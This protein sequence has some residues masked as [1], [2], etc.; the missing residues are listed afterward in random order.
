[1]LGEHSAQLS[2]EVDQ[3]EKTRSMLFLRVRVRHDAAKCNVTHK[4][5]G[6]AGI[7][8]YKVIILY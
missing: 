4:A 7:Y 2:A 3:P 5:K 6:T 8:V 1:M